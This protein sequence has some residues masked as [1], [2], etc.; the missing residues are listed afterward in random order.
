MM[1]C[2]VSSC[3]PRVSKSCNEI[4]DIALRDL[5][6]DQQ[7]LGEFHGWVETTY[8][9]EA[10]DVLSGSYRN[11]SHLTPLTNSIVW[12]S[13]DKKYAA[14]FLEANLIR[15][16]VEWNGVAPTVEEVQACLGTPQLYI[17]SYGRGVELN[18]MQ[19]DLWYLEEGVVVQS[20]V[21]SRNANPPVRIQDSK[22]YRITYVQGGALDAV[23]QSA[24]IDIPEERKEKWLQALK[25]WGDGWK[26]VLVED[27]VP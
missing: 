15:I 19:L 9:I 27:K 1:T 8:N 22:V 7:N 23:M 21:T 12:F 24:F 18:E 26:D 13:N 17:A 16:T 4:E 6:F 25:P 10:S 3:I 14:H 20:G 5:N 11:Q 2:L